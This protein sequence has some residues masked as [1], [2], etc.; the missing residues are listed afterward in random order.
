[1]NIACQR[2]S[3]SKKYNTYTQREMMRESRHTTDPCKIFNVPEGYFEQLPARL[4]EQVAKHE[5][6]KVVHRRKTVRRWIAAASVAVVVAIGGYVAFVRQGGGL[7]S[8]DVSL[9]AETSP[10]DVA[11]DE[12]LDYVMY[13][14][15]DYYAFTSEVGE[16]MSE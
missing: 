8:A 11:M 1:M 7:S 3:S 14:S 13:D 5:S 15:S 2:S 4:M 10:E 9:S 12:L 6:L 16:S